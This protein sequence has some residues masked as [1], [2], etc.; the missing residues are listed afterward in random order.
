MKPSWR[1][2]I[3]LPVIAFALSAQPSQGRGIPMS[4]GMRQGIQLDLEGK[5]VEARTAFQKEIDTA[6]TPAAKANAQ[7]AMAMSWAFDLPGTR[8]GN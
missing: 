5:G 1:F 7:R 8:N 4:E 3:A 6:V 2:S